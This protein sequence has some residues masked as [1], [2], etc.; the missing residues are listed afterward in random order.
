MLSTFKQLIKL[1]E[2]CMSVLKHREVTFLCPKVGNGSI[3]PY[4][5]QA[6]RPPCQKTTL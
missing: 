4:G 6:F 2:V 1:P 3:E 5:M